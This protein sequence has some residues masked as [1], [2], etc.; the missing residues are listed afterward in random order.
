MQKGKV[1][2]LV[3]G[4]AAIFLLS[5]PGSAAIDDLSP[6]EMLGKYI[7]YDTTL[8]NPPLQACATC[9]DPKAGWTYPF[10][11]IN[12]HSVAARGANPFKAG[13]LK[14]PSN[15]YASLV[16]P[17]RS[18]LFGPGGLCGGNFWNGRSI[19]YGGSPQPHNT[20]VI[21]PEIINSAPLDESTKSEYMRY[22]G[23]TADQALNPF[24]NPV[25]QNIAPKAV[26]RRVA[27][28]DYAE[29][30]IMAWG[31]PCNFGDYIYPGTAL[32]A[33]EVNFRR[34]AVSLAAWQASWEVNSFSSLRDIALQREL[35]RVDL[36]DTPG[37][38]PL[39]GLIDQENYGHDL[40]YGI[41]SNL[42]PLGKNAN[43]AACH[44]DNPPVLGPPG[45]PP[46]PGDDGAEPF[47]LYAEDAYHNIGVPPNP[48]IPGDPPANVGLA[49]LTDNPFHAGLHKTP[50][51]RNVDKRPNRLF[52]KAYTHNGWFKSLESLVHYYNTAFLGGSV[53]GPGGGIT[54]PYEATTAYR[55]GVTRCPENVKTERDALKCNCWPAPEYPGAQPGPPGTPPAG[56]PGPG[57][58]F[59]FG[60]LGL[61]AADEAA[62]VAYLKTLTDT[63][64]PKPPKPYRR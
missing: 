50:T 45:T 28:S 35:D 56:P 25:E 30:F 63:Y 19:G 33:Y 39:V 9:H 16:S 7:F 14:T 26:C 59:L 32:R 51:L 31:E 10:S 37:K 6:I 17:L 12:K 41:K 46:S 43:C 8:S 40:F 27:W 54:I 13:T 18:C 44:S 1:W 53:P 20:T 3:L 15:A 21:G 29:L 60:N 49:G 22:L 2:V 55:F 5:F 57:I 62:L 4:A 36:D 24:L 42:N 11:L 58:P 23:P 34:I 48:E 38:F 61:D 64:T 52:C 47:Q